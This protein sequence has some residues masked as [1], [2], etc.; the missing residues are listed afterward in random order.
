MPET[1]STLCQ[2]WDRGGGAPPRRLGAAMALPAPEQELESTSSP[3]CLEIGRWSA[4]SHPGA[5]LP[6]ET[7][8]ITNWTE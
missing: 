4:R 7:I 8:C 1:S 6:G 3:R 2:G 5:A